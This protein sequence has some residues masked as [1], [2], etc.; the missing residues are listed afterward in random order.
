MPID[1][2]CRTFWTGGPAGAAPTESIRQFATLLASGVAARTVELD[3]LIVEA[4][5]IGVSSG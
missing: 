1:E 3:P 4:A 2:V 5:E